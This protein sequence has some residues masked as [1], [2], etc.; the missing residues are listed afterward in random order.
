MRV[1]CAAGGDDL[2]G[3]WRVVT[4]LTE[5]GRDSKHGCGHIFGTFW[6][7]LAPQQGPIGG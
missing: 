7:M 5:R 6:W 1:P 4:K 3:G 2:D